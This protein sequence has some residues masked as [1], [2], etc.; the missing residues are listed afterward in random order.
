MS[1]VAPDSIR[2]HVLAWE[3]S[4]GGKVKKKKEEEVMVLP[5]VIF[6]NIWRERN[7]KVFDKVETPLQRLEEN[8]I[9]I[10]HFW[11]NGNFSSSFIDLTACVDSLY[12]GCK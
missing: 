6:W 11:K 4:F 2:N 5:L 12:L 7:R 10:L 3:G 8:F 1:W 9:K